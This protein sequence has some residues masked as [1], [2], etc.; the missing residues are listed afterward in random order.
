MAGLAFYWERYDSD[1]WLNWTP[2]RDTDLIVMLSLR[3]W[4]DRYGDA[5][6]WRSSAG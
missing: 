5:P 2:K 4:K 6:S 3:A 1:E